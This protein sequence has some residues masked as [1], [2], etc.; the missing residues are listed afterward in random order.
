MADTEATKALAGMSRSPT[1][2]ETNRMSRESDEDE[3]G[4]VID[5]T[6]TES[7]EGEV[8]GSSVMR[9]STGPGLV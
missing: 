1:R 5:E 2:R 6:S 9:G 8:G 7:G 3:P 4:N